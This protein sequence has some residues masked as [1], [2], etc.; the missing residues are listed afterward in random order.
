MDE[1]ETEA[2]RLLSLSSVDQRSIV[3][4]HRS[5]AADKAVPKADRKAAKQRAEGLAKALDRLRRKA[6]KTRNK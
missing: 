2:Q 5:V 4:L 6:K 1:I 3:A